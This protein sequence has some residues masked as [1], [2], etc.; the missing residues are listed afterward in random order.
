MEV[1]KREG[2]VFNSSKCVIKATQI[3]F[4]GSVYTSEGIKPDPAKVDDIRQMPTPQDKEE[5]FRNDNLPR[6]V[7]A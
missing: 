3:E 5:V 6:C 7:C 2:L 4:F 1:A